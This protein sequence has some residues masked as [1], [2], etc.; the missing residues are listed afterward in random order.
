MAQDYFIRKA[1]NSKG[2]SGRTMAASTQAGGEG[3]PQGNNSLGKEVKKKKK[4]Y[5]CQ[6]QFSAY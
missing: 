1:V 3:A 6:S 4:S 5:S 2:G